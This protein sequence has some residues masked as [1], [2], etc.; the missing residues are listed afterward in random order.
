MLLPPTLH[1]TPGHSNVHCRDRLGDASIRE[2]A[3]F[4]SDCG[5]PENRGKPRPRNE[6]IRQQRDRKMARG[7]EPSVD[8]NRHRLPLCCHRPEVSSML[9]HRSSTGF[10]AKG[11]I[12]R[13]IAVQT[14]IGLARSSKRKY[15]DHVSHVDALGV[16][17]KG[18]RA[19]SFFA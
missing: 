12:R 9:M 7:A 19:S 18:P 5:F 17:A 6:E 14:K 8:R 3:H 15:F 1:R 2:I 16:P 10:T 13:A 11:H 4:S